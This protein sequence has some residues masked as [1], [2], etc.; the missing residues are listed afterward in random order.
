MRTTLPTADIFMDRKEHIL[1][2]LSYDVICPDCFLV[3]REN[4]LFYRNVYDNF[5]LGKLLQTKENIIG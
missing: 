2:A 5:K 4:L 1:G 3:H